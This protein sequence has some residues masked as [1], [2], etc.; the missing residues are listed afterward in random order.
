MIDAHVFVGRSLYENSLEPSSLLETMEALGVAA[1][2]IRPLKP[3]DFDMD[4]ANR[5]VAELQSGEPRLVGF[6]RVNP[7]EPGAPEQARRAVE[8]YGLKGLH[9]HPW[10][11]NCPVNSPKVDGVIRALGDRVP[12]YVSTGFPVVSHPLQLQELAER[13]PQT[14]FIAAHGG[15]QDN[16]GMSFEDSLV[17]ARETPNV[18][19]D[20]AGVYRRD[21][22]E[23]LVETA[24]SE[25]VLFGSCTPYMDMALEIVRVRATHL[26]EQAKRNIFHDNAAR[27]L[28][29]G[30]PGS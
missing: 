14:L 30:A 23:L 6:A 27:L 2:V 9:L 1:A 26:P 18:L 22:I 12:V 28:G 10:E 4:A 21:F 8:E 25:R 7:L 19:F 17:V 3:V 11:E 15:Q 16:S 24:G 5:R 20:V 29:I 13:H